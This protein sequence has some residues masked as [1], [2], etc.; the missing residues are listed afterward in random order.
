MD[1]ACILTDPRGQERLTETENKVMQERELH[2]TRVRPNDHTHIEKQGRAKSLLAGPVGHFVKWGE[3][4][5]A[6]LMNV[7]MAP[8]MRDNGTEELHIVLKMNHYMLSLNLLPRDIY[9][10][11]FCW[12]LLF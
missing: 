2:H 1:V 10:Y 12:F 8:D 3:D 6:T 4:D 7:K 9:I 5:M 11:S